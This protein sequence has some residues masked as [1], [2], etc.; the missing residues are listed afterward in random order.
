[1]EQVPEMALIPVNKTYFYSGMASGLFPA[2]L[3][4]GRASVRT[5]E[6]IRS[7]MTRI[8]ATKRGPLEAA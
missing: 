2:P 4:S 6:S 7:A 8:A 5:V 3:K 1:M